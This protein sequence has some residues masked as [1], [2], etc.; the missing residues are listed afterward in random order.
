[1]GAPGFADRI[2]DA[3]P[4]HAGRL[5]LG[6]LSV[7]AL[8]PVPPFTCLHDA[9]VIQSLFG[10]LSAQPRS[11]DWHERPVGL[12]ATAVASGPGAV[13]VPPGL[14]CAGAARV[15]VEARS[16]SS[17]YDCVLCFE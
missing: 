7:E 2:R 6:L 5:R 8:G 15:E 17:F 3:E 1:M 12:A 13:G 14:A 16:G 9:R 10:S 4:G 11:G